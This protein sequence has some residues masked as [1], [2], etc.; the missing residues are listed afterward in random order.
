MK[1]LAIALFSLVLTLYF[2]LVS[3][4]ELV[5]APRGWD[6]N[7][8]GEARVVDN[9][10]AT[11]IIMPWQFLQSI[12]PK[13]WLSSIEYMDPPGGVVISSDGVKDEHV[14]GAYAVTRKVQFPNEK[15]ISILYLC[16]GN[17][18]HARLMM[19][20]VINGGIKDTIKGALFGEK[21]CKNEPKGA[22]SAVSEY[23]QDNGIDAPTKVEQQQQSSVSWTGISDDELRVLNQQIPAYNRPIAASIYST[24]AWVGFPAMLTF[25]VSMALEFAD[26]VKLACTQWSPIA[27]I[28]AKELKDDNDCALKADVEL[29][30]ILSFTAGERIE[31]AFGT[32]GAY[33]LE[34]GDGSASSMSGGDLSFNMNGDVVIGTWQAKGISSSSAQSA[35]AAGRKSR[36]VGRYYLAGNTISIATAD[37]DVMHGFIGYS[38]RDGRI[39]AV[40]VNGKHYWDR[41]KK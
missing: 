34:S 4:A 16:P 13:R 15:G 1:W 41:N 7:Y 36:L 12:E 8:H 23:T 29:S 19:L 5:K 21:V 22:E 32:I 20:N 17:E 28:N 25:K 2:G 35:V 27:D 26:G 33:G 37:G 24:Q 31:I 30:R 39:G 18:G 6:D 38:K 40:Y 9:G 10:N 3:G 11:V 14:P